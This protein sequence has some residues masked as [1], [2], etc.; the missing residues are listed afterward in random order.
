MQL[1]TPPSLSAHQ[2]RIITAIAKEA[3]A[4]QT[5]WEGTDYFD[6]HSAVVAQRVAEWG[7]GHYERALAVSHDVVEDTQTG[8]EELRALLSGPDMRE[9]FPEQFYTDL[10]ALTHT[11]HEPYARYLRRLMMVGSPSALRVKSADAQSNWID[12]L[13]QHYPEKHRQRGDKY[14]LALLLVQQQHWLLTGTLIPVEV[15]LQPYV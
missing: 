10:V 6:N 8:I 4:G 12:L 7:Y 14:A 3:H 13:T 11:H 2:L 5:R 9:P 1:Y 15:A